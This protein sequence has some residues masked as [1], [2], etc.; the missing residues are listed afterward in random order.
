MPCHRL[1][2]SKSFVV[3]IALTI[4]VFAGLGSIVVGGVYYNDR[5]VIALEL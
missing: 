1:K 5:L 3:A 2:R 4:A